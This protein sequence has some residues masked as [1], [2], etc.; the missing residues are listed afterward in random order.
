MA[1]TATVQNAI[2]VFKNNPGATRWLP[3]TNLKNATVAFEKKSFND[4]SFKIIKHV[5]RNDGQELKGVF[6]PDGSLSSVQQKTEKGLIETAFGGIPYDKTT[7]IWSNDGE[8]IARLG[9]KGQ[10]QRYVDA[11][12]GRNGICKEGKFD[13]TFNRMRE[14]VQS[15]KT[16]KWIQNI[17]EQCKF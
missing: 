16:P 15:A 10:P 7:R 4:G 1:I 14:E 3:K 9:H 6:Y 8:Y 5:R 17:L 2:K 13:E 12:Q 11:Y